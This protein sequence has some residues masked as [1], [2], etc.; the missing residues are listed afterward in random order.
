MRPNQVVCVRRNKLE[1]LSFVRLASSRKHWGCGPGQVVY[2]IYYRRINKGAEYGVAK[3][4]KQLKDIHK[5]IE[6]MAIEES[7]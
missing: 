6:L 7:E 3:F 2:V 1:S 5:R 4:V